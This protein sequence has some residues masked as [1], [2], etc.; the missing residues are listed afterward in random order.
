[1]YNSGHNVS[2]PYSLT[3]RS[4][5]ES[6]AA[7]VANSS[8][9]L[10]DLGIEQ[11]KRLLDVCC[12]KP[13]HLRTIR[14]GGRSVRPNSFTPATRSVKTCQLSSSIIEQLRYPGDDPGCSHAAHCPFGD[15]SDRPQRLL[16]NSVVSGAVTTAPSLLT[17][18]TCHF[19]LLIVQ[20]VCPIAASFKKRG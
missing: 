7:N 6:A 3:P 2:D 5:E 1:M 13:L 8:A 20:M 14:L 15:V 9:E 17:K 10:G 19:A 18:I 16:D 4:Y 11:A 12:N